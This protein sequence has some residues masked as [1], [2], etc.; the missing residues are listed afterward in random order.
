MKRIGA[1]QGI[2]FGSANSSGYSGYFGQPIHPTHNVSGRTLS[3]LLD[4]YDDDG[5]W[6]NYARSHTKCFAN[7]F[8]LCVTDPK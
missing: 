6:N 1:N 4:V 8:T 3:E 5:N 7:R 2:T